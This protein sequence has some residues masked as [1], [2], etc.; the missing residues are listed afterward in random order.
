MSRWLV[1]S[2]GRAAPLREITLQPL[3]GAD[4]E[5]VGRLVEQEQVG[6]REQ[7]AGEKG[8]GALSA[9][10][11]RQTQGVVRGV[12]S[13]PRQHL[14][15]ARH[16][17]VSAAPLEVVLQFPVAREDVVASLGHLGFEGVEFFLLFDET[18]ERGQARVPERPLHLEVGL[19]RKVPDPRG[20]RAG[21]RSRRGLILAVEFVLLL[22]ETLERG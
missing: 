16:V 15:D 3:H 21:Y 4:V 5:M 1:G 20:P 19:L 14:L 22:D 6:V 18:R 2:D 17:R 13:Q 8:A 7:E 10:K 11:V 9:R 12:E